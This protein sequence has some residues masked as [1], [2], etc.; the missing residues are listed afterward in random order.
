MPRKLTNAR[1]LGSISLALLAASSLMAGPTED[2]E[3]TFIWMAHPTR[4]WPANARTVAVKP[5][6]FDHSGQ[7]G[8][9]IRSNP[10]AWYTVFMGEMKNL[11]QRGLPQVKIVERIDLAVST[12]EQMMGQTGLSDGPVQPVKVRSADLSLVPRFTYSCED[13]NITIERDAGKRA[14]ERCAGMIPYVGWM[15]E[16]EKYKVINIRH[17]VVTCDLKVNSIT[18]V[19]LFTYSRSLA[20]KGL[21]RD[22][23]LGAGKTDIRD[24][25][26]THTI[27]KRLMKEHAQEFCSEFMPVRR[28]IK[29]NMRNMS[30]SLRPAVV[31]FNAGRFEEAG[32]IA[33]SRYTRSDHSDHAL[34]IL[35]LCAEANGEWMLA[36]ECYRRAAD[37]ENLQLEYLNALERVQGRETVG[38]VAGVDA[39]TETAQGT[40]QQDHPEVSEVT[41]T[42]DAQ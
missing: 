5:P 24:L 10:E 26:D 37:L 36:A 18:G 39:P 1:A 14:L 2:D 8:G 32:R 6:V 29:V 4:T 19:T 17:V 13:E 3:K 12:D 7:T 40:F 22:G 20:W 38:A 31:A 30:L 33:R 11:F 21:T 42:V 9:I 28:E 15:V 16:S 27:I 25:P 34:F 41:V 23:F 35:G